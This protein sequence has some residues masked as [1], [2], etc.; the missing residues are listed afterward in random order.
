MNLKI[1]LKS[2]FWL[3]FMIEIREIREMAITSNWTA[4]SH[5]Y[6]LF[7]TG[8][9]VFEDFEIFLTGF[10]WNFLFIEIENSLDFGNK[11]MF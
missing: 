7:K 4:S 1:Y 6:T 11:Y 10:D 8:K 5:K 2:K 3:I 9:M